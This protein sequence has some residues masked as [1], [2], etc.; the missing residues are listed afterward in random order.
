MRFVAP[1][2]LGHL[3]VDLEKLHHRTLLWKDILLVNPLPR[4]ERLHASAVK[5]I[6]TGRLW[7]Y[8]IVLREHTVNV[9]EG[10]SWWLAQTGH[11][12]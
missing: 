7:R 9:G 10:T 1:I 6:E 4:S 12:S 8:S 5:L 2:E 11:L 3:S